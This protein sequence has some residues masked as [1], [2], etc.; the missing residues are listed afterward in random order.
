MP[1]EHDARRP[2]A[3]AAAREQQLLVLVRPLGGHAQHHARARRARAARAA[4]PRATRL[5]RRGGRPAPCGTTAKRAGS[6]PSTR[7]DLVARGGRAR[8]Q[9]VRPARGAQ[10]RSAAWPSVVTAVEGA[11]Q[12]EGHVVQRDRGSARRPGPA[13][14]SRGCGARPRA[15]PREARQQHLLG[16]RAP[17]RWPSSHGSARTRAQSP[18]P[19]RAQ[20]ARAAAASSRRSAASSGASRR[21]P[22][23]APRR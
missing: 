6:S 18:Q 23:R 12:E 17:Q 1:G 10:R 22:A 11:P 21:A 15:A 5:A 7:A 16:E 14:G 19:S 4:P 3:G 2:P 13:R 8:D 20:R 9:R